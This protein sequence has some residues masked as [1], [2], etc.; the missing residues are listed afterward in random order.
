MLIHMQDGESELNA[1]VGRNVFLLRKQ[2][3]GISQSELAS[4]LAAEL[5]K[6]KVDPTTITRM[7]SGKR[8]ITVADLEALSRIFSIG[9]DQLLEE[10]ADEL[11]SLKRFI[12]DW[13]ADSARIAAAEM[14]MTGLPTQAMELVRRHPNLLSSLADWERK[15]YDE[16]QRSENPEP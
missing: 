9:V 6:S 13:A 7:E 16:M 2:A 11:V 4:R 5:G 1:R 10:N 15:T 12:A 14:R 8:P 3:L